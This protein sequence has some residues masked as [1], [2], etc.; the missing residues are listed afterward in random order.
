MD[1]IP[2]P[3]GSGHDVQAASKIV[4]SVVCD[5]VDPPVVIWDLVAARVQQ[6]Y[7]PASVPM[8]QMRRKRNAPT[9]CEIKWYCNQY[10]HRE[11]CPAEMPHVFVD[12]QW[13]NSVAVPITA[14]GPTW[15]DFSEGGTCL[16]SIN[17]GLMLGLLNLF[18]GRPYPCDHVLTLPPNF[19]N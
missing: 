12:E 1:V 15:T 6:C 2:R 18:N 17:A 4:K 14:D 10:M 19:F 11:L 5:Q 16:V 3:A 9:D 8:F 7:E 13:Y